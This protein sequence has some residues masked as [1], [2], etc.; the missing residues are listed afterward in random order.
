LSTDQGRV[1]SFFSSTLL[2]GDRLF[3]SAG[4]EEPL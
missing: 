3:R 1:D 2:Q 4:H